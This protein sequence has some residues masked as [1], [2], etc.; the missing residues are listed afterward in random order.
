MAVPGFT[1]QTSHP[2]T[3]EHN[4]RRL[5]SIMVY[6]EETSG[7]VKQIRAR[8]SELRIEKELN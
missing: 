5:D 4:L 1:P 3:D 7:S 2:K 8:L 6:V